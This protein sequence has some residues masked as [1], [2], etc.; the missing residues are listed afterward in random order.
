MCVWDLLIHKREIALIEDAFRTLAWNRV[1]RCTT[2]SKWH[3]L[4]TFLA[5]TAVKLTVTPRSHHL[6][7]SFSIIDRGGFFRRLFAS[8]A[9]KRGWRKAFCS[10]I[11]SNSCWSGQ[12]SRKGFLSSEDTLPPEN[13]VLVTRWKNHKPELLASPQYQ[14]SKPQWCFQEIFQMHNICVRHEIFG[15]HELV[16]FLVF[17]SCPQASWELKTNCKHVTTPRLSVQGQGKKYTLIGLKGSNQCKEI[18][19]F[20]LCIQCIYKCLKVSEMWDWIC[21]LV[22]TPFGKKNVSFKSREIIF[23]VRWCRWR[24]AERSRIVKHLPQLQIKSQILSVWIPMHSEDG[25]WSREKGW[26]AQLRSA[27]L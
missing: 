9:G 8:D 1:F 22:G 25:T 15:L 13:A 2:A 3:W 23:R 5:K 19:I 17:L 4:K 11:G 26:R 18:L 27:D 24:A 14:T 16:S 21:V 20:P 6:H 12:G 7:I 10:A